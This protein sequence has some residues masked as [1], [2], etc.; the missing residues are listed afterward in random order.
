MSNKNEH[1]VAIIIGAICDKSKI[2]PDRLKS[3]KT[4][5]VGSWLKW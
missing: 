3:E 1:K 2:N 5:T 4:C